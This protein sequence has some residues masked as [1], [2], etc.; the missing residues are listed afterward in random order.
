VLTRLLFGL[1]QPLP[2]PKRV[3]DIVQDF[4]AKFV[5]LMNYEELFE[6]VLAANYLDINP[7][8]ELCLARVARNLVSK[9]PRFSSL[10]QKM[11]R[12]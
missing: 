8:L 5:Y 11:N 7:L 9:C 4:Y 6:L 12:K 10:G 2:W 3:N 1:P